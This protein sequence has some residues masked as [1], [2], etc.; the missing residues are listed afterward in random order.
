[1]LIAATLAALVLTGVLGALLMIGRSGYNASSYSVA[2]AEIQR[3]LDT[4]A[5]D[6]RQA[7]DIRWISDQCI[8]LTVPTASDATQLVTYAYDADRDSSTYACFCRQAGAVDS[9]APRQVL[10]HGVDSGFGFSRF[11]VEQP[12]VTDNTATNDLET[13]LIALNLRT[14][15]TG[16]TTVAATQTAISARFVL[17][18]KRVAN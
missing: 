15:H 7:S 3:G 5:E 2:E 12:G 11:K 16:M 13:K 18:N 8:T 17:R 10:V 6:V 14:T 4:F 1:V 9:A